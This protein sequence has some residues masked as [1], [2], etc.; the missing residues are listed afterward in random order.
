MVVKVEMCVAC[1]MTVRGGWGWKRERERVGEKEREIEKERIIIGKRMWDETAYIIVGWNY[2][3]C[4]HQSN[5]A[6]IN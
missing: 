5:F 3:H 2:T 6:L 1:H 4:Y